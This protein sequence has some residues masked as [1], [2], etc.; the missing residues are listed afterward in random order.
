MNIFSKVAD[1]LERGEDLVL[2][3]VLNRSGSAPRSAG[4]RMIVRADGTI[5]GTVGGGILEAAV[6]KTARDVF[7]SKLPELKEFQLSDGEAGRIG[8]LCGG[9]VEVLVQFLDSST[10]GWLEFYREAAAEVSGHT[11]SRLITEMPGGGESHPSQW[12]LTKDGATAGPSGRRL[13]EEAAIT[14]QLLAAPQGYFEIGGRKYHVET[15]YN[16]GTSYIFGAGHVG[17]ALA[18]LAPVVGFRTVVL[19]DREQ[20]AARNRLESADEV[21]VPKSFARALE[22]LSI[23]EDSFIV[24]VTRGHAYDRTILGQALKTDAGYIGMIGSRR[25]R[26]AIYEAL[27]AECGFGPQ[28]FARVHSPVGLAIGAE[29]PEEIAVSI[30]AEMI[31]VRAEKNR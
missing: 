22:G 3:T 9:H 23:D 16:S 19:D 5:I 1:I 4:A 10:G 17:R 11:R 13:P 8:M 15:L 25:K 2:A 31:Q 20:F 18:Q 6:Q 26:D 30:I 29:T 24:I 28:D 14:S 21:I 12:L 7:R 27:A